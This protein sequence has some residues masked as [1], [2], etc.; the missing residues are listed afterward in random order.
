MWLRDIP[1]YFWFISP[2][3][4]HFKH[5]N[6]QRNIQPF[7]FEPEYADGEE[8]A[9]ED[10]V[11]E[12]ETYQPGN[13][14]LGNT[15]WCTCGRCSHTHSLHES[16]CCAEHE[17]ITVKLDGD[18]CITNTER[19][20]CLCL[21]QDVLRISL[22]Q[23]HII[24]RKGNIPDPVPNKLVIRTPPPSWEW[25]LLIIDL[26]I[27]LRVSCFRISIINLVIFSENYWFVSSSM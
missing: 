18:R 17:H 19:F 8:P 5:I 12:R 23:A 6:M 26:G 3:K 14:R 7:E 2:A 4:W 9:A 10:R 22:I 16:Y 13:D 25:G 27:V 15:N 24:L 21:D 11:C 1:Y 20:R